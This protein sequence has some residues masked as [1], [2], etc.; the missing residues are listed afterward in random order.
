M[1]VLGG[2][3]FSYER[4]TPVQKFATITCMV[5]LRGKFHLC[6]NFSI[7]CMVHLRNNFELPKSNELL[8]VWRLV[9][10]PGR[11]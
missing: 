5:H 9:E 8:L 11:A 3:A 7:T 2:G 4:G 10:G 6:S 1:T